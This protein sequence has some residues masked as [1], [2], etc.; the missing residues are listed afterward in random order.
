MFSLIDLSLYRSAIYN[1]S[2]NNSFLYDILTTAWSRIW[3]FRNIIST[4]SLSCFGRTN[5]NCW[6]W[7][8][9]KFNW[10]RSLV[11]FLFWCLIPFVFSTVKSFETLES[12]FFSIVQNKM[13]RRPISSYIKVF[14]WICMMKIKNVKQISFFK[15]N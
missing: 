2:A 12:F 1:W 5:D 6:S 15:D 8:N 3:I 11:Y 14:V 7:R 13:I 4:N 9:I 10:I